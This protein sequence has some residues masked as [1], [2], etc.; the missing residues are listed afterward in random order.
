MRLGGDT[1]FIGCDLVAGFQ[2]VNDANWARTLSFPG[3][4]TFEHL[5]A[6]P[7]GLPPYGSQRYRGSAVRVKLRLLPGTP[8]GNP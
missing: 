7:M 8:R 2:A 4:Y 6:G 1:A 5:F 3:A